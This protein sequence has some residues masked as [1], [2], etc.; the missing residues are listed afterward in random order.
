MTN[1]LLRI[2]IGY[3]SK[4]PLAYAVLA[5]SILSRATI[6]IAIIPITR[7]SVARIYTRARGPTETT[8]FSMT[9]FLVPFLS[10]YEGYSVFL[11][12]D[13]LC[14]VD[15][16]ELWAEVLMQPDKAV[17]C[18][19]HDYTPSSAVKF[20]NQPQTV[21]PRK[22]WSS[23]MVFDNARCQALTPDYVNT[24]SGLDLH[25]FAWLDPPDAIGGLPLTW[26]WLV[27]EYPKNDDAKILHFTLG[28]PW[29]PETAQTD[30][31]D[32]WQAERLAMGAD[33]PVGAG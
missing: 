2:F 4:E 18:C 19:Q 11:D 28:G 14:R 32:L 22:N 24:A 25:R 1:P 13:M 3:D 23:F 33:V 20:L 15:I 29:F 27:W 21:Y 12:C 7:Q 16:L 10:G 9:R 8:E 5:H 17:L 6:P 31:A 30:H 26:N